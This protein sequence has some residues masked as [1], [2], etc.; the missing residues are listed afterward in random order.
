M[1]PW[2]S[3]GPGAEDRRAWRVHLAVGVTSMEIV[4]K[5]DRRW[6]KGASGHAHADQRCHQQMTQQE[7]GE[8]HFEASKEQL[9]RQGQRSEASAEETS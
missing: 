5:G 8:G 3:A 7:G 4:Q 9:A 6:G 2:S 1:S